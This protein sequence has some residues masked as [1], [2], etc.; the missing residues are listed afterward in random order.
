MRTHVDKYGMASGPKLGVFAPVVERTN[1]RSIYRKFL[2][3]P[4]DVT[5]RKHSGRKE[6]CVAFGVFAQR[7]RDSH[8]LESVH[9]GA[10][11]G[12][13]AGVLLEAHKHATRTVAPRAGQMGQVNQGASV[14]LPKTIGIQL[15][16]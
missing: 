4:H 15:Y 9:I 14:Y 6:N 3:N 13:F 1:W 7:R 10:T 5:K 2:K 11:H 12:Q 16:G 8:R